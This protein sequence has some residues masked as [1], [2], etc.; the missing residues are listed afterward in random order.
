M[1]I[2]IMMVLTHLS[3]GEVKRRT[4]TRRWYQ[5][6]FLYMAVPA[7]RASLMLWS[8]RK[9]YEWVWVASMAPAW[10]HQPWWP[11]NLL[12]GL[13][14]GKCGFCLW[15]LP[16]P[17]EVQWQTHGSQCLIA[18]SPQACLPLLHYLMLLVLTFLVHWSLAF[19][20]CNFTQSVL[21]II[22]FPSVYWPQI[23]RAPLPALTPGNPPGSTALSCSRGRFRPW[24]SQIPWYWLLA[25]L[26]SCFLTILKL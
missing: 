3:R 14:Y 7:I 24:F 18:A 8:N 16:L 25:V 5:E 23:F 11:R 6:S 20:V 22:R 12:L 2:L 19:D 10:L 21:Q 4:N 26:G 15:L 17:R 9:G 1:L 13:Y